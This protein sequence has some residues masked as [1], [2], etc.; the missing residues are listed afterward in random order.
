MFVQTP[1]NSLHVRGRPRGLGTRLDIQWN[2]SKCSHTMIMFQI[3]LCKN[4]NNNGIYTTFN[5]RSQANSTFRHT[6]HIYIRITQKY[7]YKV[8][9]TWTKS[10]VHVGAKRKSIASAASHSRNDGESTGPTAELLETYRATVT[11]AKRCTNAR[12]HVRNTTYRSGW[13]GEGVGEGRG[14]KR[15]RE[16][17]RERELV[18]K[19]WLDSSCHKYCDL[20]G[21]KQGF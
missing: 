5:S 3:L 8:I 12:I 2:Y 20:I 21:E 9:T 13:E 19:L 6:L 7:N 14:W 11:R 16:R 4:N 15:E 17:E 18:N 10:I 1:S